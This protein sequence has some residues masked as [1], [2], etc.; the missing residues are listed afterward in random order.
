MPTTK[1]NPTSRFAANRVPRET[2][3]ARV[4][5]R[6]IE[7]RRILSSRRRLVVSG[8]T[9]ELYSYERPYFYNRPPESRSGAAATANTSGKGRRADNLSSAR[10]RIRRLISANETAYGERL[11][12]VTFTFARNVKDL[13]EAN[14]LW[15]EYARKMRERHGSLKYL[16]V[17]EFQKRGAIHYHVLYFNLPFI[18]GVKDALAKTWGHGFVKIV[19]VAHVRNLGAYVSKYLQKDIMDRRLVGEKAFFCSK[20]LV[21]PEEF[22][23]EASIDKILAECSLSSEVVRDYTSSHFGAIKYIQGKLS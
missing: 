6:D 15:A 3:A 9:Y 4:S 1:K 22:R 5:L 17:V 16:A 13:S 8:D 7:R 11:K 14:K 2:L 21:Q 18:Y 10:A 20:G 23:N 19:T 12:F